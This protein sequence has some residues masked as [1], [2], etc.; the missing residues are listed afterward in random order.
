M[1]IMTILL[2]LSLLP[3]QLV[4]TMA[5]PIME[6]MKKVKNPRATCDRL[7]NL[8][9]SLLAQLRAMVER[10]TCKKAS[11][12][13][14]EFRGVWVESLKCTVHHNHHIAKSHVMIVDLPIGKQY[15]VLA[16]VVS[17]T[18]EGLGY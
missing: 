7:Y 12:E 8:I 11:V 2:P 18:G 4:P 14:V 5:K 1:E 6:A 3:L 15:N 17:Y 13:A 10:R 9:K 16:K